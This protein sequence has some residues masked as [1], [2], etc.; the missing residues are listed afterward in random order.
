MSQPE[1][2]REGF[3]AIE[4]EDSPD[5]AINIAGRWYRDQRIVAS[6]DQIERVRL[7]RLC[8][9]CFEPQERPFPKECRAFW[10][11]FPMREQQ[12]KIFAHQYEGEHDLRTDDDA[13]E[14]EAMVA[15]N[16]RRRR[17]KA[18]GISIPGG[19]R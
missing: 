3:R 7:G 16:E 19:S 8:L 10:C 9:A 17:L 4:M 1:R 13:R 14:Q 2:W 5:D 15:E 18:R 12:A 11:R 6:P